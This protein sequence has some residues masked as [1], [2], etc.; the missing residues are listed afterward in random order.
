MLTPFSGY[1]YK[2][3]IADKEYDSR[4]KNPER[5]IRSKGKGYKL[6]PLKGTFCL[7]R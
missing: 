4:A 7:P 3:R 1:K 5:T 6:E 2:L